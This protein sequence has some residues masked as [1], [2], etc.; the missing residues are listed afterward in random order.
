MTARFDDIDRR[1]ASIERRIGETRDEIELMLKSELLGHLTHFETQIDEKI[2]ESSPLA[3]QLSKPLK[4][5]AKILFSAA[6][7]TRPNRQAWR[8]RSAVGH[9]GCCRPNCASPGQC[10]IGGA[11]ETAAN[12]R[13]T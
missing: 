10:V 11:K 13:R 3:S 6:G 2:A 7:E 9:S 8:R 4:A 1:F 5:G 12:G